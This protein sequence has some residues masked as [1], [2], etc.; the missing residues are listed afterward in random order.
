MA[1]PIRLADVSRSVEVLKRSR[2]YVLKLLAAAPL[3]EDDGGFCFQ[4]AA[5]L[6]ATLRDLVPLSRGD[7]ERIFVYLKGK[8]FVELRVLK[9]EAAS[10]L[11]GSQSLAARITSH[12]QDL[13]DGTIQDVGVDLG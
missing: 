1:D 6:E 12:G 13:V 8:N 4:A 10:A 2:G 7:I 9:S 5:Q 3:G 11:F